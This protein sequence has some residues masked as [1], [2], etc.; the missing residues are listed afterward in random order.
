MATAGTAAAND[1]H[2]NHCHPWETNT[3]VGSPGADILIGSQCDDYIYGLRGSD[4]LVGS[5]GEDHL[6]GGRGNDRLR[7]V[8]G[9]A[10]V[11]RGGRGHFDRCRG[12]QLDIFTGCEF[13]LR[14]YVTP[15]HH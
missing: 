13:V 3:I 1:R 4:L 15:V 11:L 14:F 2:H 5:G 6:F 10:D 7:G 9:Y 8:D 12:D